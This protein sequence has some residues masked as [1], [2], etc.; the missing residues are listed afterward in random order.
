MKEAKISASGRWRDRVLC[1][2]AP[3]ASVKDDR[4]VLLASTCTSVADEVIE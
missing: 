1:N 4:I 3:P 2:F